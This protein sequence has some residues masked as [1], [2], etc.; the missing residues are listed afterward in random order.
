MTEHTGASYEAIAGKYAETVDDRPWNA[1]YERPAVLSLLPP[2]AHAKVLDVGCGSGWYTEYLLGRGAVV[3]AFDLNGEFVALTQARVGERAR[4]LQAD[5]A[6]PLDF[7]KEGE[8]DVVVCSLVMHYLK[9]WHAALREFHRVL[10][11]DGVLVFS[12]H[13]PFMDWKLFNT[14]DYF[15]VELLE[16]DWEIGKVRFY[17]RPLTAISHALEAAGFHIERLLE[18]RPTEEFRRVHPEGYERLMKNP[19]FLV[20]RARKKDVKLSD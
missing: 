8:F 2:L 3:T 10:H 20:V 15:A 14:E 6:D 11:R 4:V 13:H 12:T 17:R 9:D 16:D 19:W 5:L 18:P 1:F 7:A